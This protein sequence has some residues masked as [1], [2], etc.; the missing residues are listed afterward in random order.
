M[1]RLGKVVEMPAHDVEVQ[2]YVLWPIGLK[3]RQIP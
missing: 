1:Q 2:P 3:S